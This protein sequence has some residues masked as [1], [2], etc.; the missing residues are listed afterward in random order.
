ML[1]EEKL[2]TLGA[3]YAKHFS[4]ELDTVRLRTG[5]LTERLKIDH[6]EAAAVLP[7]LDAQHLLM[8]RQ[9]RY[10]IARETL[11]LPAGKVDPGEAVEICAQR[12]LLEETGYQARRF[13]HLTSYFPAIGYSN[14]TIRIYAA[15]GL[16][17]VSA[18]QAIQA[19]DE[20]SRVE[21]LSLTEVQNLILQGAIND[22]KTIIGISLYLAKHQHGEIPEDFFA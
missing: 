11:E 15:S 6:P 22:G 2:R 9:W 14:E 21:V 19:V 16:Q 4:V 13:L 10:A 20:I 8:V 3:L 5:R 17:R 18:D 12:E 1:M 7:F